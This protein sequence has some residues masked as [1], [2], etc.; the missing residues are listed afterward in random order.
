MFQIARDNFWVDEEVKGYLKER[1]YASSK[2]ITT[3][4]YDAIC[5]HFKT[6]APPKGSNA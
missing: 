4:K 6:T 2:D 5:E 1:G 3:D